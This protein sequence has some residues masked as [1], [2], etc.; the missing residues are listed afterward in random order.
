MDIT[1][2]Y[3]KLPEYWQKHPLAARAARLG[4]EWLPLLT[5]IGYAAGSFFCGGMALL[6]PYLM[7]PATGLAMITLLRHL[8]NRSRPYDKL[9]I[10]PL[11]PIKS[12]KG[13]SFPSR[14][15]ASAVLIAVAC[16]QLHPV[17]GLIMGFLSVLVAISRVLSG[18]HY[19]SDIA[20]GA[21]LSLL[22]GLVGFWAFHPF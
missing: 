5:A 17:F 14:H 1:G 19:L 8:W 9:K 11:V 18:V 7:V 13:H 15:T 22:W 4:V 6:V 2:F 10:Q 16:W 12:G 21:V 3:R 20:A